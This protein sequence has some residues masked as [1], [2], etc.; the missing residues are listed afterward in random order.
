MMTSPFLKKKYLYFIGFIFL[1]FVLYENCEISSGEVRIFSYVYQTKSTS[2]SKND[3]QTFVINLDRSPKRYAQ[4]AP[5]LEKNHLNY[6]RFSA[7]DGYKLKIKN[8]QTGEGFLASDIANKEMSNKIHYT[9]SCPSFDSSY[10]PKKDK[11]SHLS[12]GELGC[13]CSHM[14]IWKRVI[15]SNIKYALVLEDDALLLPNFEAKFDKIIHNLPVN[16]DVVFLHLGVV[17]SKTLFI[18][19]NKYLHKIKRKGR[20]FWH[21]TGY[22]INVDATRKLFDYAQTYSVPIDIAISHAVDAKKINVYKAFEN[23]IIPNEEDESIITQ[24]GRSLK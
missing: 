15:S 1:A 9:V 5:Q 2:I 11:K 4:L 8:P 7:V 14:E 24:M 6:E 13:Y 22:L 19:H 16:W 3:I 21:T 23:I 20:H 12:A 18:K 10:L 17:P